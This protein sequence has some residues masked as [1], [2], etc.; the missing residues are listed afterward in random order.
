MLARWRLRLGPRKKTKQALWELTVRIAVVLLNSFF[1]HSARSYFSS[2]LIVNRDD[3]SHANF[4]Y[5]SK[6]S[7]RMRL[8]L[9]FSS[10][11]IVSLNY[12]C[13]SYYKNVLRISSAP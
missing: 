5:L 9:R 10:V 12:V 6:Y 4:P 8:I 11:S 13:A 7:T 2:Y 3:G 1:K